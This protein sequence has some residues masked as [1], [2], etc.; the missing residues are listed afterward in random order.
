MNAKTKNVL[1]T[2]LLVVSTGTTCVSLI[3]NVALARAASQVTQATPVTTASTSST[4]AAPSGLVDLTYAAEKSINAV[5][6]IRVTQNSKTQTVETYDPFQDFFG[7]FFG[8]GNGGTQRRQI[9]TPKREAAG[10][11]VIIES[12]GYIVTNNHVVENADEIMV[13][14]ND[15]REYKG[16][17]IGTDKATDL[18]LI[19]IE[20]KDLPSLPMGDSN[21]LKVGEWVIAVGNPFNLTSTVTAGIISAKARNLGYSPSGIQSFIQ[22]DAAIN[23]GNSGGALVNAAGELVG[24][25][26]MIYSQTGSYT[27]YGFAVPTTIVKKVVSDLKQFGTVQRA[28]L[29]ISG[30]DVT[31]Y[32]DSEKQK[33]NE[34]PD[35]GTTEGVYVSEVSD[36]SAA[37]E[38][39]LKKGDVVTEINGNRIT[40]MSELQEAIGVLQPGDK[41]KVTYLRNKKSNT[42]TVTLKNAQGNT[43]V[44]KNDDTVDKLGVALRDVSASECNRLG[45]SGGVEVSAIKK[46]KMM[47][48]GI[49]K[50]LII[51][52]V[53]D[54][55]VKSVDEFEEAVESANRSKDRTLWLRAITP[56]GIKRSYVVELDSDSKKTDSKKTDSKKK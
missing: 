43:E 15:N 13:K 2:T 28:L 25:N 51:Y 45:I 32:I 20:E 3:G 14:L 24:I 33:G 35:F 21:A 36:G 52:Q 17:I 27:G 31:N 37:E 8:R 18:A 5:V 41:A 6:Y 44:L 56:S 30:T 53:N 7:D 40:K 54:K 4:P 22:T 34:A 39:G 11:G 10:S 23:S 48:E 12:N 16:R 29:G 55:A 38:A 19:K 1:M 9:Q 47:D 46:G 50:G 42:C 49:T 26:S